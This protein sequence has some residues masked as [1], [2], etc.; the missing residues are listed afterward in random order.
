MTEVSGGRGRTASARLLDVAGPEMYLRNPFRVTGL[1]TDAT[2]RQVRERRQMVLSVLTLGASLPT[3]D[4]R[5]PLPS[6]PSADEVRAAFDELDKT[7]FRLVDELFWW[8]GEPGKCGC[9]ERTH[10]LHDEAV[11][12]HAEVLDLEKTSGGTPA[13]RSSRWADAARAWS[14]ALRHQEFWSHLEHRVRA[15]ADRRLDESTVD[16]LRASVAHALLAPQVALASTTSE[17]GQVGKLLEKW[18]FDRT[19]LDD[20]RTAAAAHAYDHVDA[21]RKE[22]A[23]LL[24]DGKLDVTA[25]R[26]FKELVP[27]ASRLN[28]L[29][30]H[31]RFRRC[32][33]ARNRVAV[34][35]N[36]TA[37]ALMDVP[38]EAA[39]TRVDRLLVEAE[40]LAVDQETLTTVRNNK[41]H[42]HSER[43]L[44]SATGMADPWAEVNKLLGERKYLATVPLLLSIKKSTNDLAVHRRIGEILEDIRTI[45]T[46]SL[47][48]DQS[49]RAGN[50]MTV[51]FCTA[52]IVVLSLMVGLIGSAEL[53]VSIPIVAVLSPFA[54]A[55][56][57]TNWFL[58]KPMQLRVWVGVNWLLTAF[59]LVLFAVP[60][61]GFQSVWWSALLFV[62]SLFYA[63]P[64][65]RVFARL[66]D[67]R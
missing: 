32:S 62:L 23:Q 33:V 18:D 38:A 26:I 28:Q 41:V 63:R 29:V 4:I 11:K 48:A 51:A 46:Q 44:V 17:P 58:A 14:E 66:W 59:G 45:R 16:G 20:A 39:S 35:V 13:S 57:Y 47:G 43:E 21:L 54:L 36:N 2:G 64:L 15:L 24:E 9:D 27:A 42:W 31:Q 49:R 52:F 61:A 50:F 65:G 6:A 60:L 55:V 3:G 25:T 67:A 37:L 53:S 40:K 1:P 10:R 22:L 7:E 8:W 12:A 19:T 34:V 5:L 30:P 56:T